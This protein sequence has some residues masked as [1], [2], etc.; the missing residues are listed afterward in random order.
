MSKSCMDCADHEVVADPDPDDWF[1]DD[2]C[3]VICKAAREEPT[4]GSKYAADSSSFRRVT[5]SCRPY[6]LRKETQVPDWC[7]KRA[8]GRT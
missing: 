6:N 1:C 3:A 7:P 2:D 8:Q 5:V 4:K